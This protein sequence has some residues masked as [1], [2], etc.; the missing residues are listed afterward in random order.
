[1]YV[2][3]VLARMFQCAYGYNK[4]CDILRFGCLGP[5]YD[6]FRIVVGK[7][8]F[9]LLLLYIIKETCSIK[10]IGTHGDTLVLSSSFL[11]LNLFI[12]RLRCSLTHFI[13]MDAKVYLELLIFLSENTF[14]L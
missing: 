11:I 10:C 3:Y 14:Q 2:V 12:F 7:I 6:Y 4:R 13:Y 1:M 9:C 8:S 5:F